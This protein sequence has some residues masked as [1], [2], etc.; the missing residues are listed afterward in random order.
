MLEKPYHFQEQLIELSLSIS[1]MKYKVIFFDWYKTLSNSLF[2][3]QLVDRN[4]KRHSWNNNINKFLFV[5]N[6]E[7]VNDWMRGVFDEKYIAKII[8][9]KFGYSEDKII[10][11]LAD[12]CRK[13]EIVDNSV[14]NII[15][16]IRDKG[17]K[18]VIATDN[19]DTFMKY[20]KP[21]LELEKYFDDFLVSFEEK[22]KKFETNKDSIP[23]FDSYLNKNNLEYKDALLIDDCIDKSD[24][25]AKLGF[26]I[27][28]IHNSKDFVNKLDKIHDKLT[29]NRE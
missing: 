13:M 2:W 8:F 29:K 11:Y 9:N 5:E 3:S 19:M 28:Q 22:E 12:S 6:K 10:E 18:C 4:H 7:V 26:D 23:F 1:I 14:L 24:V 21:S 25:Y 17:I 15:N 27:L 16:S 20:T